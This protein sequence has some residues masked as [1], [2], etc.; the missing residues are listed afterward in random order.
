MLVYFAPCGMGLGHAARTLAIAKM[1]KTKGHEVVFSTYGDAVMFLKS[2]G[3][4]VLV[5]HEITYEEDDEGGIDLRL[6]IARGPGSLYRF[7]RQVAA[8]LYYMGVFKPDIIVSDSRL[9]SS[10][11][12]LFRRIPFILISNQLVVKIP[13]KRKLRRGLKF[14]KSL[15]ESVLLEITMNIWSRSKLILIPDFPPPYTISREN[16]AFGEE[17]SGKTVLIGPLISVMPHELPPREAIRK[18]IG[19]ENRYLIFISVSGTQGEK[20]KM[21]EKIKSVL[22][23][24]NFP[25]EFLII[26]SAG[27]AEKKDLVEKL[28]ENVIL[29]YWIPNKF[30]YLKAADIFISHGGHTSLAEGM[31]YGIPQ[32]MIPSLSHTERMGN[33]KSIEDMGLGVLLPL[34]EVSP[35]TLKKTMEE[36]LNNQHY[37]TRAQEVAEEVRKINATA[38]AAELILEVANSPEF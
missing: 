35:R 5:S 8:E 23:E 14:L 29:Y 32:I 37:Y 36:V 27:C 2:Q 22:K 21:L 1:V 3:E 25:K 17:Y 9:S 38:R 20:E 33:S 6:T 26:V 18:K 16:L 19:V 7:S 30:E 13:V 31:Y 4:R 12:A 10:L 24:A 28:A 11:A 34:E 15:A